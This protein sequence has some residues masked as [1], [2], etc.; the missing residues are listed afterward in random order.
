MLHLCKQP[1]GGEFV[2][3]LPRSSE[4]GNAILPYTINRMDE[5]MFH[6]T[7][8]DLDR[9]IERIEEFLKQRKQ[10]AKHDSDLKTKLRQL[11]KEREQL[12]VSWPLQKAS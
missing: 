5:A 6:E 11:Q 3:H 1:S 2:G 9:Q 8:Q 4:Q 7:L 12:L 10:L